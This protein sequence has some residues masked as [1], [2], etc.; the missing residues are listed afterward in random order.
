MFFDILG[1]IEGE[2]PLLFSCGIIKKK[3][4][5]AKLDI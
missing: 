5:H 2:K 4:P 1:E 3:K